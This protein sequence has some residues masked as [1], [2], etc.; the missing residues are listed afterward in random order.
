MADGKD[1]VGLSVRAAVE[2]Q[3]SSGVGRCLNGQ[4]ERTPDAVGCLP[5][6]WVMPFVSRGRL[7]GN[8]AL[9]LL[10]GAGCQSSPIYRGSQSPPDDPTPVAPEIVPVSTT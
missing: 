1:R 6:E 2:E 4:S 10:L 5:R 7:L 8:L 9:L 3:G